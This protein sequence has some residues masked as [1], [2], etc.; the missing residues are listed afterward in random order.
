M[1]H[2]LFPN[3][4]L[5]DAW[6]SFLAAAWSLSTE[7]QFY[8]L[9]LLLGRTRMSVE[10]LVTAFLLLAVAGLAWDMSAPE[11]WRFSR[12]F[13]PNKANLPPQR[14]MLSARANARLDQAGAGPAIAQTSRPTTDSPKTGPQSRESK[15]R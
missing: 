9:A 6:N 15:F 14:T 3:A 13:L 8:V 4:L 10:R 5:P 11:A 7:W 2:G 12:A 1:T